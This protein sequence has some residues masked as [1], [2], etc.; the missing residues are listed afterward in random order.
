MDA[1]VKDGVELTR[2]YVYKMCSPS[3]TAFQSGRNPIHVSVVNTKETYNNPKDRVSGW[4]AM[5]VNMTGLGEVMLKAGYST[6]YYGKWDAGMATPLHSPLGRGYQHSLFYF[7]HQNDYW[8]AATQPDE[9][10]AGDTTCPGFPSDRGPRDLWEDDHPAHEHVNSVNCSQKNQGKG[11]VYEDQ[12]FADRVFDAIRAQNASSS[13]PFFIFWAPHAVHDPLEVPQA[14]ASRFDFLGPPNGRWERQFYMAIV[15]Y[16]DEKIGEAVK[17]LHEQQLWD[18]TFVIVHADNG[19]AI[20]DNGGAGGNNWP[21]KGGKVSN[22][23]GGIR[24]NAFV[25]GGLLPQHVRGTRNNVLMAGWDWYA[26]LARL[27]GVSPHDERAAAAELPPLDSYD[28][29][30]VLIGANNTSSR[31]ELAIGTDGNFIG[32]GKSMKSHVGGLIQGRYKILVQSVIPMSGWTGP[33]FPNFTHSNLNYALQDCLATPFLGCLY[34]LEADPEERHNL[35]RHKPELWH[36]MHKRLHAIDKTAFSPDRGHV[37]VQAACV[38]VERYGGFWGPWAELEAWEE[39][40][41]RT[42]GVGREYVV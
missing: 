36:E 42:W 41:G 13:R 38:Q 20:Y 14:Y 16:I 2:H 18:N 27:A 25:S 8:T 39:A 11:C 3:R 34:D 35:A 1:L 30:P 24:V 9:Q 12:L 15:A 21:L 4:S 19:G 37:D 22:W 32:I 23:E 26:T 10:D 7:H 6:H 33:V 29:W 28:M 40:R 5:P 31:T 17:L